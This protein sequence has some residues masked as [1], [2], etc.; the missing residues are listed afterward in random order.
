[1]A[2]KTIQIQNITGLHARPAAQFVRLASKFESEVELI[3]DGIAVNGKSI[4]GV[5]SLAAEKGSFLTIRALGSDDVQTLNEL[6]ELMEKI[7]KEEPL[8]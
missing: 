5:M 8:E 2:E 4:L 3:K 1:M 6:V 7:F